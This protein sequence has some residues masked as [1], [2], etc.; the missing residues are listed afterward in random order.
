M[1]I[2]TI[3]GNGSG[4]SGDYGP[5]TNALIGNPTGLAVDTVGDIFF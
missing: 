3:A 5:P 1:A 4:L 2:T